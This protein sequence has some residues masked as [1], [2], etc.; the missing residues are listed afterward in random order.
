M[1]LQPQ[2]GNMVP[3]FTS[4]LTFAI[5]QLNSQIRSVSVAVMRT[6]A[7]AETYPACHK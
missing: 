5:S 4:T 3:G 1:L 2:M 6:H 7:V